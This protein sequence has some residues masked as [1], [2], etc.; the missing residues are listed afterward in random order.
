MLRITTEAMSAAIGGCDSMTIN[1]FDNT[2][3][4]ADEFSY[5]NARNIQIILKGESYFDKTIDTAAGSYYIESLTD[6]IAEASWKV[7][8]TI[9]ENGGYIE[10]LKSGFIKEEIEN[11]NL[12][13]KNDIASRKQVFLGTNQY[14][15]LEE[16]MLDNIQ[17]HASLTD[18]GGLRIE[19]GSQEFEAIRLATEAHVKAGY[20]CPKVFLLTIGNLAMRK[21]R[22]GFIT[23][24]F[25]CGGFDIIDNL[26]FKT[27]EDGVK[28]ALKAK[29]DIVV[30]CSSDEEYAEF[31]PQICK[32]YNEKSPETI[33]IIAGN[34]A[35]K[36]ELK[37]AGVDDFLN[38]KSNVLETLAKYQVVLGI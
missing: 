25:G 9:E 16:K 12:K 11:S 36:E 38:V 14:P 31:G 4:K 24:F 15:N 7:F 18:L 28:A 6:L 1:A 37:D 23:N 2:F 3:K 13:R 35:N 8:Q 34:P 32:L 29:A 27:S 30:I 17:P 22:A 19:R 21:A 10:A 5:R 20:N 33:I 26:G